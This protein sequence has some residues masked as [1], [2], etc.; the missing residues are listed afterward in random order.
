MRNYE[1][2]VQYVVISEVYYNPFRD[3]EWVEIYNPTGRAIDLSNYKIGDAERPDSF[4]GM[5]KFP[6]GTTIPGQGVL[7]IAY[8][9]NRV[10]DADFELY[11]FNPAIPEMLDYPAWGDPKYDWGL[12]NQGDQVL[13]LGPNDNRVDVVVWGTATYPGVVPHPGAEK[14]THSLQRYPPG[15]DTN[16]CA[17]DFRSFPTSIGEVLFP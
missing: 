2:P 4:E 6:P 12:N 8:N 14:S 16:D 11:D 3:G 7:V 5:V 17:F 1:P 15:Y 10:P 13:L 9:G